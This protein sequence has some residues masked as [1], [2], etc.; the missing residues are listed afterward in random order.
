MVKLLR[1]FQKKPPAAKVSEAKRALDSIAA[2]P[3]EVPKLSPCEQAEKLGRE[4]AEAERCAGAYSAIFR[5]EKDVLAKK[6]LE[7]ARLFIRSGSD[8]GAAEMYAK[9]LQYSGA[10]EQAAIASE[11]NENVLRFVNMLLGQEIN[12][13]ERMEEMFRSFWRF[14][15]DERL[16]NACKMHVL[17]WRFCSLVYEGRIFEFGALAKDFRNVL[18]TKMLGPH[19]RKV[20][21]SFVRRLEQSGSTLERAWRTRNFF[22]QH[23]D[24]FWAQLDPGAPKQ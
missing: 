24:V 18:G 23:R 2:R 6:S 20:V 14:A 15:K 17:G 16:R 19:E 13:F 11:A 9:A 8:I 7:A 10:P 5:L 21:W 12:A 1:L 3:R 4:V 22:L